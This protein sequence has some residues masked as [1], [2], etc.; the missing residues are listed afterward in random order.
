MR[1]TITPIMYG[2]APLLGIEEKRESANTMG[3]M[4]A[5]TLP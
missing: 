1:L 5:G 2:F 3:V 4:P